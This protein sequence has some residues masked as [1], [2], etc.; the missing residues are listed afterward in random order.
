MKIIAGMLGVSLAFALLVNADART[1]RARAP[2][3]AA[4]VAT[5]PAAAAGGPTP[6]GSFHDWSAY[7][8]GAGDM[9]VCYALAE[10]K[11]KEPARAKR[12]PVYFLINDWP[13]R[14]SKA[15]AEIVAGYPYKD[16]SSVGIQVGGAKFSFFTKNQG[17]AGGAWVLN[18]ADQPKLIDAMR[19]GSTAIVAGTS[20]RGTQTRDT[21]SLAGMGD[22]LDKIHQACGM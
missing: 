20:R 19:N 5:A 4:A 11:S 7:A 22:A 16:G 17:N 12:D 8:R 9:K 15:E 2:A 3:K 14:H 6:L 21:Y 10:P 13:G 18:P 1:H